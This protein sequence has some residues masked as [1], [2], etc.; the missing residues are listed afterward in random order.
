MG[1]THE[2]LHF[3]GMQPHLY[4]KI[5]KSNKLLIEFT[6]MFLYNVTVLNR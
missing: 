2:N 1:K 4:M 5:I 6:C 3:T